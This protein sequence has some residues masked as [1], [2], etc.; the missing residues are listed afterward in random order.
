LEKRQISATKACP[1][2]PVNGFMAENW[3]NNEKAHKDQVG[4]KP[5]FTKTPV[6]KDGTRCNNQ[7]GIHT[8]NNVSNKS[9][10]STKNFI[11]PVAYAEKVGIKWGKQNN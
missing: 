1:L 8:R 4:L 11:K 3:V 5:D 6:L 7:F 2:P 10:L 9:P